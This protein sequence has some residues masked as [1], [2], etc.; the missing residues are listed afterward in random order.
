MRSSK[1]FWSLL[2]ALVMVISL[3]GG[4]GLV[5]AADDGI[6][7]TP[8]ATYNGVTVTMTATGVGEDMTVFDLA[9]IGYGTGLEYCLWFEHDGTFSFDKDVTLTYQGSPKAEV[10]AGEANKIS[11]GVWGECYLQ[12][13]DGNMLMILDKE[14]PGNFASLAADTPLSQ[15]PGSINGEAAP[16][17]SGTAAGAAAAAGGP[18]AKASSLDAGK[19]Y[20]IVA[21][22]GG[23]YYAMANASGSIT[24]EE[25]TVADGAVAEADAALVW[26]PTAENY[27]QSKSDPSRY[28]FAG[29]GG[30]MLWTSDIQRVFT[31]DAATETVA[32]HTK[33]WLKFDGEKFDET[34]S[35]DEATKILLFAADGAPAAQ[36][37]KPDYPDPEGV[38]RAAKKNADGSITLAFSSDVHYNGVNMNLKTW[39]EASGIDYI[40]SFGFCGDIGGATAPNIPTY[41]SW[42]TEVED[43]MDS[44]VAAGKVGSV[45][46]TQGNH[47]WFPSA[48]GSFK[49]QFTNYPAAEE[50]KRL[51]EAVKTEDYIIYCFGAGDGA[52]TYV[53]DY[54]PDD[55]AV[56][57]EYLSTAPTDIPIFILTHYPLHAWN[58]PSSLRVM[59]HAG[60]VIDVLNK[61]PNTILLWGH[62]HTEFDDNYFDPKFPGDE[63]VIDGAG[64]TRKINFT[65]L[66]AGCTSDAEYT[67]PA[68]GSA[69][70]FNKGLIVTIQPDGG[71]KY[72][73][74]TMDGQLMNVESPWMVRFR[75]GSGDYAVID[76]QFVEDGKTAADVEVPEVEGY[77]FVGWFTWVNGVEQAFDFSAPVTRNALVTAKYSK[78]LYPVAAPDAVNCVT[79]T[80]DAAFNGASL[81]MTAAGVDDLIT[82]FDLASIGYGTGLEYGF[83]FDADGVVGFDQDVTLYYQG[84]A[85]DFTLKAGEFYSVAGLGECYLYLDDGNML[86]LIEK[87]AP[88]NFASLPGD[89]PFSAFPGTAGPVAIE[90]M[91]SNQKLTVDG[92]EVEIDHYN[93]NGN[94]YFKLRDL[95]CIL[96]GT[97]NAFDVGYDTESRTISLTTGKAYAPI[98]GDMVIGED[99]SASVV[100]SNQPVLVDGISA[101]FTAF[102]IGGNN[103]FKLRDLA[104]YL[105]Y[106]VGYDSATR[107]AQI[108][109]K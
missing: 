38:E 97:A 100:R 52:S 9:S 55:I 4:I 25:I 5:G 89:Q 107:T 65:T 13:D 75:S 84:N 81:T 96:N 76:T 80:P 71:L 46:F 40:D 88:G 24:A 59:S 48:G 99:K 20:L 49:T 105:G 93:I 92:A 21:A 77:E 63:I 66:G 64:T 22:S 11:D 78:I 6:T 14:N 50:F 29:S 1:K 56:M 85:T 43:Y 8:T 31:Y 44:L 86:L 83:W 10:K 104:D 68:A 94:N 91:V 33:Y 95:A 57:D 18:F 47:E 32:M 7:V 2:L 103:Y 54:D 87:E 41:W 106:G 79:V 108:I 90:C 39:V 42:V 53:C 60:E 15:F 16:A 34:E 101:S 17:S 67:G 58:G 3:F 74:V 36:P 69:A 109:T 51:G 23:K 102:N 62:N 72:N 26:I 82:V 27:L 35:K 73:Y 45:V 19:E 37:A 70:T 12:L 98:A 61:Y 28:V 30:F